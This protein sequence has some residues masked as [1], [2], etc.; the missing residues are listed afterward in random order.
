M[1]IVHKNCFSIRNCQVI[2][3]SNCYHLLTV[4]SICSGHDYSAL[5]AIVRCRGL[6][7]AVLVA[8]LMLGCEL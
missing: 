1:V 7:C 3:K 4:A 8:M 6:T 5:G 2:G